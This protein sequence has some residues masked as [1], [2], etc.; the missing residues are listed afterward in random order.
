[1][2]IFLALTTKLFEQQYRRMKHEGQDLPI[3]AA[4]HRVFSGVNNGNK[5][6][7]RI[8]GQSKNSNNRD[9]NFTRVR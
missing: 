4:L 5:L 7:T 9:G 2:I 1:M 3:V 8:N 6:K